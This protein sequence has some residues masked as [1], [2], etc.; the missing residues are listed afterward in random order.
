MPT[1]G[2]GHEARPLWYAN[3]AHGTGPAYTVITVTAVPDG[4]AWERLARR[5]QRGDLRQW[6]GESTASDVELV[7]P[8]LTS[9]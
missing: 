7:A 5:I 8:V 2:V 6:M 9:D 4:A 3:H 1:L